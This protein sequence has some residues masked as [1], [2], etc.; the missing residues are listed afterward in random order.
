MKIIK[1][2][3]ED[4]SLRP[5]MDVLDDIKSIYEASGEIGTVIHLD[6]NDVNDVCG[7]N[8]NH[9]E[10]FERD[11]KSKI[12]WGIENTG[13]TLQVHPPVNS[14]CIT[15]HGTDELWFFICRLLDCIR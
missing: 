12:L 13:D 6:T 9:E 2:T 11:L 4:G 8:L 5:A 14:K 3:C 7:I 15:I 1:C 10:P